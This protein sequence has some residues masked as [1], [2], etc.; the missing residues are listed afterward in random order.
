M[1]A[2]RGST[3]LASGRT[4]KRERENGPSRFDLGNYRKSGGDALKRFE[5]T[6]LFILVSL[7]FLRIASLFDIG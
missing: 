5:R 4:R 2:D 3:S 1:S 7:A 6:L